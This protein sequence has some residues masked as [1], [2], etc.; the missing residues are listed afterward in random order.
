MKLDPATLRYMSNAIRQRAAIGCILC[1]IA[2]ATPAQDADQ[3]LVSASNAKVTVTDYEASILRIPEQDRF[4]W[5]VSQERVNKE[6]DTILR[7]RLTANEARRLGL[8]KDP[9]LEA[10]VNLYRERLLG[11]AVAAKIDAE[12]VKEF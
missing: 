7:N 5:A 12:S 9:L 3:T 4:G 6:I 11:E 8:D 2:G 1:A 10:R